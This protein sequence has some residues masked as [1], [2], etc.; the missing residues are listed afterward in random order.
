MMVGEID[1]NIKY[2]V[3]SNEKVLTTIVEMIGGEDIL[4]NEAK[5]K[6]EIKKVLEYDIGHAVTAANVNDVY[7]ALKKLNK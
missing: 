5:A 2:N 4:E 7:E 6:E 1:K 3:I